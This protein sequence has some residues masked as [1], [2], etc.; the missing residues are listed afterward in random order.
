MLKVFHFLQPAI[1][2]GFFSSNLGDVSPN[3]K[4]A[5]CEFSGHPCDN[6]FQL[7]EARERCF[8]SGPGEDMFDSTRIV[9]TAVADA[10]LVSWSAELEKSA[11]A[12]KHSFSSYR[13]STVS[14][15]VVSPFNLCTSCCLLKVSKR[16]IVA[17][18]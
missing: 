14:K 5:R 2:A 3:T 9:G 10:A 4:G 1:V 6:H 18:L 15:V 11:I 13:A 12:F 8:A 7:C 16:N 17:A